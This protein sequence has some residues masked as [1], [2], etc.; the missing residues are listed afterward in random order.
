VYVR[1]RPCVVFFTHEDLR[2]IT[3]GEF[4]DELWHTNSLVMDK[5]S[6]SD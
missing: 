3:M 4:G 5:P 6:R 1:K 2:M